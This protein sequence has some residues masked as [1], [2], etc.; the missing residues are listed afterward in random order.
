A[1]D[2]IGPAKGDHL[3][4]GNVRIGIGENDFLK[5]AGFRD[6]IFHAQ[7]YRKSPCVSSILLP[8]RKEFGAFVER[9]A[10]LLERAGLPAIVVLGWGK[11]VIRIQ[12]PRIWLNMDYYYNNRERSDFDQF[13]VE[14]V[15][16][17]VTRSLQEPPVSGTST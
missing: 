3:R 16:A 5:G 7:I 9:C 11:T 17:S 4:K 10:A 12:S 14:N 13:L 8:F 15:R 2:T 1:H 6:L